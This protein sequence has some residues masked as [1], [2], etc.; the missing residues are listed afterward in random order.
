MTTSGTRLRSS[1]SSSR[2]ASGD[3]GTA[4]IREI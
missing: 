1:V 2:R 4:V 3:D